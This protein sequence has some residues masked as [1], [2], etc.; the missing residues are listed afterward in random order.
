[1]GGIYKFCDKP[2][3]L[4]LSMSDQNQWID[5]T[6][7]I[8]EVANVTYSISRDWSFLKPAAIL[9]CLCCHGISLA[10]HTWNVVRAIVFTYIQRSHISVSGTSALFFRKSALFGGWMQLVKS[11][12]IYI[13]GPYS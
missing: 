9:F 1:M 13:K 7:A 3:L 12:M 6:P 5:I 8:K 11:G 2:Q 10:S 4:L